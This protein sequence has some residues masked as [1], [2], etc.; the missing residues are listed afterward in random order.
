M[1]I[2]NSFMAVFIVIILCILVFMVTMAKTRQLLLIHKYYFVAS[3]MI[4]TWL[5]ALIAVKFTDPNDTWLLWV[6]DST[7]YIGCAVTPVFSVLFSIAFSKGYEKKMP[8]KYYWLFAVPILTN[9]IV[10]TNPF[11]HLFYRHFALDN[12]S[13][14]FGPY[15]YVHTLYTFG[16]SIA[17]MII[18]VRCAIK[19]RTK[20]HIQQA[21]LFSVGILIPIVVSVLVMLRIVEATFAVTPLSFVVTIGF[22][23]FLIYRLHLFDVKPVAMQHLIDVMS[24]C[25]LVTDLSGIVINYNQPFK[26]IFGSQYGIR[27]NLHLKD[28]LKDEDVENKTGIYNLLTAIESC[29]NSHS[30]I[31]YEQAISAYRD[32]ELKKFYYMAEISP[33]TVKGEVCGYLA[34]FKDV[35]NLKDNMQKL[36]DSQLK[37]MERER[38]AFLGQMVGGLAH[39]LKTP[40]MSVAGSA[41]A[42]ENLVQE[43]RES[44]GDLEVTPDDYR[45][46][47]GEMNGWLQKVHDACS[48]MSDII[49]AVKGQA[50]NMSE[51]E[52]AE[53]SIDETLKRVTLLLRHELLSSGCVLR[54][55]NH[56]DEE[57]YLN[58]DINNL[59]QVINNLVSNA[60][61][62]QKPQGKRDIVVG[63]GKD[64]AS[65]TITVKDY[66]CGIPPEVRR[67]LFKQ[68][69]TSKGTMGTGLGV[70]ISDSVIRAKFDGTM[71]AE[72]NPEGGSIFGIAIPLENVKFTSNQAAG[73]VKNI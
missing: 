46:I 32:G 52:N 4:I 15:M 65:F 33:L 53:F 73:R 16:C 31:S 59:V 18:I 37:M 6:W 11:H 55:E 66:G 22:N 14:V 69:I 49:S 61:D 67:K 51:S 68:M 25:Y 60:I 36:Q 10:W 57:I 24:D 64:G 13:V 45:E 50:S 40:I 34:I 19:T 39:N 26:E 71:W 17:A 41:S 2:S 5:L 3:A 54:V 23:G 48:Y 1:Y 70:F 47:Y 7:T 42:I 29:Q 44:I 56:I 8:R 43:C 9:I 20:L 72:E 27:E 30:A 63:I 28:C 35:T 12:T 62:A 38:L 21:I 58:G